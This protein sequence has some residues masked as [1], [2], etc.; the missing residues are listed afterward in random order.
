M[1][2]SANNCLRLNLL[3]GIFV[4][5]ASQVPGNKDRQRFGGVSRGRRN[6]VYRRTMDISHKVASGPDSMRK[7]ESQIAR[8][9]DS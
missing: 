6:D 5:R 2:L 1:L 8:N 9:P 4:S 7:R 3:A